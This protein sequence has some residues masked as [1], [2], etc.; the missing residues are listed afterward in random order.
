LPLVLRRGFAVILIKRYP[1]RKLYDTSAKRYVSLEGVAELIRD[2]EDIQVV[3][4]ASGDDV[5][6][7]ILAQ[8]IAEQER[9]QGGFLP[10][11]VLTG[12]IQAGGETLTALRRSMA[13][14][15]DILRQVD[16]EIERRLDRLVRRGQLAE[17][18][19]QRL[20]ELLLARG[21]SALEAIHPPDQILAS[22]RSRYGLPSRADVLA[23]SEQ[24]DALARE[25]D[26]LR[27]KARPETAS[28]GVS[29]SPP[30]GDAPEDQGARGRDVHT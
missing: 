22:V 29:P 30:L 5:T 15:L 3:D 16:E 26:G 17:E 24:I 21:Q 12:W 28:P 7:L 13:A 25:V 23:L 27:E 2:G 10:L 4:H 18:E 8:I 11:S 1:N 20:R 14:Q 6:I 9:R 19:G